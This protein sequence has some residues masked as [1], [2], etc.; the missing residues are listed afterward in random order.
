M[1]I[2][3]RLISIPEDIKEEIRY[4]LDTSGN[5]Y[6]SI[7]LNNGTLVDPPEY[8]EVCDVC[9]YP[10]RDHAPNCFIGIMEEVTS[11]RN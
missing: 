5:L 3:N 10:E 2:S 6:S 9:S 8:M 7:L 4:F 11:E 1:S